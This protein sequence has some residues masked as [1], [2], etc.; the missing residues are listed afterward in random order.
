L[1]FAQKEKDMGFHGKA[2]SG[3][4]DTPLI[5][6][7]NH[8]ARMVAALNLGWHERIYKDSKKW[9]EKL[10]FGWQLLDIDA[11]GTIFKDY[12]RTFLPQSEL[13]KLMEKLR[14]SA[15][16]DG[17]DIQPLKMLGEPC[18]VTTVQST[19]KGGRVY[20]KIDTIAPVP[21]GM[22]VAPATLERLV[23]EL[24][25]GKPWPA[26]SWL[27]THLYGETIAD[28]LARAKKDKPTIPMSANR[29]SSSSAAVSTNG[30]AQSTDSATPMASAPAAPSDPPF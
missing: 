22:V 14:G 23:W 18:L 4:G 30:T 20:A 13:R 21:A 8:P 17:E 19:S 15:Y 26:V 7:G 6:K 2:T 10:L 29:A 9:E 1:H 11:P 25:D 3:A 24:A 5:P 27:L 12:S 28:L 16:Q